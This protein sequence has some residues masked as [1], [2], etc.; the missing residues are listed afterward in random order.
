MWIKNIFCFLLCLS[1]FS[2]LAACDDSE[3]KVS[4]TEVD[5]RNMRAHIRITATDNSYSRVEAELAYT[6]LL[7]GVVVLQQGDQ[8]TVNSTALAEAVAMKSVAGLSSSVYGADLPVG[9][10]ETEFVVSLDRSTPPD[11]SDLWFPEGL[12]EHPDFEDSFISAPNSVIVLPSSFVLTNV[13]GPEYT[14]LDEQVEL[15]WSNS[16]SGDTMRLEWQSSCSLGPQASSASV[17]GA[18]AISGDP[19]MVSVT[20]QDIM[21]EQTYQEGLLC[22]VVLTVMRER[23]GVAD[24]KFAGG[25]VVIGA[26]Q[27]EI[28]VQ[29]IWSGE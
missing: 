10:S 2:I 29:F 9:V 25:S 18:R 11:T 3:T 12:V 8:F 5:T 13:T 16:S 23:I 6:Q 14:E 24:P 26:Q 27:R 17:V 19:G 7:N 28:A 4:S 22:Q 15:T 21:A 1:L 20:L